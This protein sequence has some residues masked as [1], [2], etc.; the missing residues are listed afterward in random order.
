[1]PIIGHALAGIAIAQQFESTGPGS[2]FTHGR[3]VARALWMPLIVAI[4]Y[5]PDVATH[6]AHVWMGHEP[7]QALGH[8]IPFGLLAGAVIGVVWAAVVGGPARLLATIAAGAIVLHDTMDLLQ[9]SERV[10]FWPLSTRQMGVDWFAEPNRLWGEVLAFAMPFALFEV[11]RATRRRPRPAASRPPVQPGVVWAGRGLVLAVLLGALTVLSLREMR[12]RQMD[13]A[14][15]M[16]R[17]GR[18]AEALAQVERAERWPSSF[19]AGDIT[20]G[21]AYDGLG[22]RARAEAAFLRA[23][24]RNPDEFWPVAV[25]AQH[26]AAHGT[27]EER[28]QRSAPFVETLRRQFADEDAL[29][30]VLDGIERSIMRAAEEHSLPSSESEVRSAR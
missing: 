17:A 11:W 13:E 7:A 18:F 19:G 28:R 3:P 26:Y 16:R 5:L 14:I 2:S 12:E 15:A 1:M 25:L 20:R 24:D 6:V 23:Y 4:S 9:D 22:D 30:R 29:G 21:E 8:S 10:P 27:R